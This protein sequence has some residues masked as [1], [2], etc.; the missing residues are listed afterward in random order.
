MVAE[1][2]GA[3]EPASPTAGGAHLTDQLGQLTD[4][5]SPTAKKLFRHTQYVKFMYRV[6]TVHC[7]LWWSLSNCSLVQRWEGGQILTEKKSV[8]LTEKATKKGIWSYNYCS[9]LVILPAK[10]WSSPFYAI[11]KHITNPNQIHTQTNKYTERQTNSKHKGENA[12]LCKLSTDIF[13]PSQ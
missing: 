1:P 13:L 12:I 4:T 7:N 9:V 3:R 10:L 8:F 6:R 11:T 5:L 2:S